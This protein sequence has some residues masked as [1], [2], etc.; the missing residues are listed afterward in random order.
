MKVLDGGVTLKKTRGSAST[1]ALAL[2]SLLWI[3]ASRPNCVVCSCPESCA[4]TQL[5]TIGARECPVL[6]ASGLAG[7]R[8]LI[9]Y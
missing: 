2:F 9:W 5:D 3:P 8:R 7:F 4:K 6:T 1:E